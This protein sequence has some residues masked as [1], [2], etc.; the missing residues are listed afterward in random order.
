MAYHD[1][2]SSLLLKTSPMPKRRGH[3]F[4]IL[5]G[6]AAAGKGKEIQLVSRIKGWFKKKSAPCIFISVHLFYDV[7]FLSFCNT[8]Q[9]DS[10]TAADSGSEKPKSHLPSVSLQSAL[11]HLSLERERAL[12]EGRP[13]RRG[14]ARQW[15]VSFNGGRP[16]KRPSAIAVGRDGTTDTPQEC[17]WKTGHPSWR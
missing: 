9:K 12:G 2:V 15:T 1:K 4:S 14:C 3:T 16:R 7:V 17:R 6:G 13:P 11:R 8:L 5:Q 10:A